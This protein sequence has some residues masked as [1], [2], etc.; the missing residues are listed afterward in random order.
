MGLC[1]RRSSFFERRSSFFEQQRHCSLICR[2]PQPRL[3][4]GST[5]VPSSLGGNERFAL[6]TKPRSQLRPSYQHGKLHG[7]NGPLPN[8]G[9]PSILELQSG[10]GHPNR[11]QGEILFGS[12]R[13]ISG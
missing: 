3:G 11:R 8:R 13:W 1:E 6:E 2:A 12:P 9:P 4:I 10:T 7:R 5:V